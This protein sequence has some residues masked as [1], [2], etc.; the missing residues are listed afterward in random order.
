MV[1]HLPPERHG[2]RV[3]VVATSSSKRQAQIEA[4]WQLPRQR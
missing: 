2:L 4:E 1:S 3:G